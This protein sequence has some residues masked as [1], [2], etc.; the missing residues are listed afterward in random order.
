MALERKPVMLRLSPE[1]YEALALVAEVQDKD[2]GEA[3]REMLE[4]LLL[5]K[6]HMTK[7]AAERFARAI[8]SVK[9]D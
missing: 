8:K 1:A 5:G 6:A 3:G 7:M 2:L 4:E 9:R